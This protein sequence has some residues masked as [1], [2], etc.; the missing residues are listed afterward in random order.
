M[1]HLLGWKDQTNC[2]CELVS[3]H[4]HQNQPPLIWIK[5]NAQ[6]TLAMVEQSCMK[7]EQILKPHQNRNAAKPPLTTPSRQCSSSGG[8][9]RKIFINPHHA[10]HMQRLTLI[11]DQWS[12][13]SC[14]THHYSHNV[15][16]L[17]YIW[18]AAVLDNPFRFYP[19]KKN[20]Q[21]PIHLLK[22]LINT[23]Q[24]AVHSFRR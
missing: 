14:V 8:R 9:T 12:Q 1:S 21:T 11:S 10:F 13:F 24:T 2:C 4:K 6:H 19:P 22:R 16:M 20:K 18:G 15:F 23:K 7:T 3:H 17:I 5:T